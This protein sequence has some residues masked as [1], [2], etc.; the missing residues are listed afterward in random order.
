MENYN[1]D[2]L[3][4]FKTEVY[5]E[6]LLQHEVDCLHKLLLRVEC[7]ETF[8]IAHELVTRNKITNKVKALIKAIGDS[9]LRPFNFLLNKN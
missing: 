5:N 6:D 3:V 8:C 4:L 9:K 7:N 1:R 2:L